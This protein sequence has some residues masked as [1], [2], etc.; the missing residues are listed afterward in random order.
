[1]LLKV[2]KLPRMEK[3]EN[4]TR[5]DSLR[6]HG[7]TRTEGEAHPCS[8]SFPLHSHSDIRLC[9][10]AEDRTENGRVCENRKSTSLGYRE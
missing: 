3:E 7:H 4:R 9:S 8:C 10:Q 5:R 2:R 6:T 1:M